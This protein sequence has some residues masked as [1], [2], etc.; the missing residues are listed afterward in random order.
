M[1]TAGR[2]RVQTKAKDVRLDCKKIQTPPP[3]REK[4]LAHFEPFLV[5]ADSACHVN[6]KFESREYPAGTT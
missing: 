6:L 1:N 3:H 4:G 5:F 2:E